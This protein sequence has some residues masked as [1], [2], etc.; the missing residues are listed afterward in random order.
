MSCVYIGAEK[1]S[2]SFLQR[3]LCDNKAILLSDVSINYINKVG[4]AKNVVRSCKNK[5]N[6]NVLESLVDHDVDNVLI[7]EFFYRDLYLQES[8]DIFKKI[9]DDSLVSYKVVLYVRDQVDWIESFYSTYIKNG[10]TLGFDDY[11]EFFLSKDN[12]CIDFYSRICIWKKSFDK[13]LDVRQFDGR[14][15]LCDIYS[16]MN[17]PSSFNFV[18]PE[19]VNSSLPIEDLEMLRMVNLL[20]CDDRCKYMN[21]DVR[22]KIKSLLVN[23]SVGSNRVSVNDKQRER[24]VR[25]YSEGN[26]LLNSEFN[27]YL[28]S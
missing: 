25:H 17:I 24:I 20:C 15:I 10:K 7:S 5:S 22:K 8:I 28:S 11:I 3:T 6:D 21:E 18:L 16:D 19:R 26:R 23:N 4:F 27:L 14:P 12:Q 13:S 2:T 1:T 9:L